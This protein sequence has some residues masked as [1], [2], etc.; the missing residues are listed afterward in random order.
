MSIK[1]TKN[2][3]LLTIFN[4]PNIDKKIWNYD[5]LSSNPNI[6]FR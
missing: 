2:N 4:N 1:F 6:D 5:Y 3:E